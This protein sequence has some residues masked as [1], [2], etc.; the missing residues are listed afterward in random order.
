M[1][2][3]DIL[4]ILFG[5]FSGD[6]AAR[7]IDLDHAVSSVEE[8]DRP[9]IREL[10]QEE[11]H[12]RKPLEPDTA[13]L[14]AAL[15]RRLGADEHE[16]IGMLN[17]CTQAE[18]SQEQYEFISQAVF[19]DGKP[20]SGDFL[21][22]LT[23]Y[24]Y[25]DSSVIFRRAETLISSQPRPA[26]APLLLHLY[27]LFMR[28]D[29]SRQHRRLILLLLHKLC[30]GELLDLEGHP[31]LQEFE[32]YRSR[33]R[34]GYTF[35][36]RTRSAERGEVKSASYY[37]DK[38][39]KDSGSGEADDGDVEPGSEKEDR[40]RKAAPAEM[41]TT[42]GSKEASGRDAGGARKKDSERSGAGDLGKPGPTVSRNARADSARAA[43]PE[44]HPEPEKNAARNHAGPDTRGRQDA[45]SEFTTGRLEPQG[46]HQDLPAG[47]G[48]KQRR[49]VRLLLPA[50][51]GAAL[52]LAVT[53]VFFHR[54][55]EN[56]GVG[57]TTVQYPAEEEGFNGGERAPETGER[58]VDAAAG[59]IQ[60]SQIDGGEPSQGQTEGEEPPRDR[61]DEGEIQQGQM[62]EGEA[63]QGYHPDQEEARNNYTVRQGD[64]L[65]AISQQYYLGASKY[66]LLAEINRLENPHLIHPGDRIVIPS[67]AE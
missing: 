40:L 1:G 27:L 31:L 19:P 23:Q 17:N 12:K 67:P 37:L 7:G 2:K 45:P 53:L 50:S 54:A 41:N 26:P 43:S 44:G 55:R 51:I 38:Y 6:L 28:S 22:Q 36:P 59:E 4:D 24:T 32:R 49:A 13:M 10:V 9:A 29:L 57:D 25:L 39:F 15:L 35:E 62:E 21:Y 64:T 14:C 3:A 66:P 60:Q 30:P 8:E 48:P 56:G 58:N 33:N 42:R 5:R 18:I 46:N 47:G 34:S 52:L 61:P 65:S 16:L 20:V 63:H 11:A